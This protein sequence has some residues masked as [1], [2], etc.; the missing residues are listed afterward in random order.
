MRC[1]SARRKPCTSLNASL[2]RHRRNRSA[3]VSRAAASSPHTA[4]RRSFRLLGL[5][6]QHRTPQLARNS[7]TTASPPSSFSVSR[8]RRQP[9]LLGFSLGSGPAAAIVNTA[10]PD[11]LFLCAAFTSFRDAVCA[12]GLP[13][14]FSPL[15]PPLWPA[16]ESLRD[17]TCLC[18]GRPLRKRSPLPRSNGARLAACAPYPL[19]S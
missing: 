16:Q 11:H 2:P 12:I 6:P 19:K 4:F 17:C 18:T 1:S 10:A 14:R 13:A 9:P 5:W 8:T 7:I 3:L 15:V